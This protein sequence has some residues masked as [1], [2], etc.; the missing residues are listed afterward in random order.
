MWRII[1]L[2]FADYLCQG[3]SRG[4][5]EFNM[6]KS[7]RSHDSLTTYIKRRLP[8]QP[9]FLMGALTLPKLATS[10]MQLFNVVDASMLLY[11]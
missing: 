2:R 6:V 10:I 1:T 5:D 8:S 4:H 7:S 9:A 11:G 3:Y